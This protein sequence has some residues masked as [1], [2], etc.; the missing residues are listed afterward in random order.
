MSIIIIQNKNKNSNNQFSNG[1]PQIE[2]NHRNNHNGHNRNNYDSDDSDNSDAMRERYR[3]EFSGEASS[4]SSSDDNILVR[5][6]F[7]FPTLTPTF[8]PGMLYF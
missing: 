5:R 6:N 4:S 2:E 1:K 3:R 8:P 7:E